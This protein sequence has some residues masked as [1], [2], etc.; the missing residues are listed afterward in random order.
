MVIGD[1]KRMDPNLFIVKGDNYKINIDKKGFECI[2][3]IISG[4]KF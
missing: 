3:R 1:F 2:Q 4:P